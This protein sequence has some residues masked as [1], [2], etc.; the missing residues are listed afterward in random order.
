MNFRQRL[1]ICI[2]F[3]AR[4]AY[5]G[6]PNPVRY[7]GIEHGLSN[8]AV[9]CI[10]QD[11]NGF[12]W[13]GTYDGLNRY[14]GYVF[15][16][17]RNIIGDSA[18]L[19]DNHIYTIA[20]GADHKIWIGGAKG[21]SIFN[22]ALSGFSSP[23]FMSWDRPVVKDIKEG[24]GIIKTIHQ[25]ALVLA[26]T[27]NGLL[28]FE[29]NNLVGKQIP[30][31]PFKGQEG[32]YT[33]TS[34]EYDSLKQF[35]W[36]FVQQ[37]GLCRFDIKTRTLAVV[38]NSIKEA[39]CMKFDNGG[40]LW[41]GNN[42]GLYK[43]D[44]HR[45]SYSRN[46]M[47][48]KNSVAG[49]CID[50]QNTVWIA[51]DGGGVWFLS[52]AALTPVPYLS[53]EGTPLVNSN[54]VYAIY[55]DTE[56][57]KWIGT[58]RGGINI[59][60]PRTSSFRNITYTV[61]GQNNIINNFILS[62][63][64][65]EK[66][67][68]WIGTDGAGLRYWDR[69][70]NKSV[71]YSN[72]PSQKNS[73]SSNFITSILRDSRNTIWVSTWFG[74]INRLTNHAGVF[75]HYTCFNPKTNAEENNVWLLY[76]DRQQ[77]IWASTT[78][79]GTLYLFN[80]KSNK[81]EIFDESIINIQCLAEDSEGNFWGGNYT[82]L[83]AIDRVQ[84]KHHQYNIGYPVRCI[85]EDK[86]K[87]FWIG[88]EGG[89]LLLFDRN[90][91]SYQRYTTTEG[92]PSNTILRL[93]EDS[94][95]NLW[96]STYNGL[97]KFNPSTKTS[98]NF[99][100]SDG[101]QSNQFSFNAALALKTGEFL[102]GGIKG[103]NIF[104][105][106][107]VY[108][109]TETPRIFLT[110]LK[111]NNTP[112]EE[113]NSYITKREFEKIS[114]V[115]V[116][117]DRAIVS[118]D[119]IALEYTGADKIKYAYLLEGWDKNW[120][121]VNGIRGANY[122]RLQEGDYTFKIKVTNAD[123]I[124]GRETQL[125]KIT[126]LPP[127]YRTWWIYLLYALSVATA[128][129]LYIQYNKRQERLRYEIKLA[130]LEKEK[131]KELTEKKISFFTHISHEFRT[132]LT[133]IINPLKEL[134]KGK[135]GQDESRKDISMIYRNARR[136]LSLVDQLLLFRKVESIDQQM[137]I[138]KFDI[139]EVCHEVF[140]SFSQHAVAKKVNFIYNRSDHE[141]FIYADK[142]KIEIILF[143]LVSNA[144][145]YTNAGGRITLVIAEDEKNVEI[146]VKDTGSGIPPGI[147]NK[148]FDSFYQADNKDK[149]SQTGFG[150]G[151]YVSQK[152][153]LAH[154]GKL[155][156][157]SE[158]GKGT[159][160]HLVL[161]KGKQHFPPQYISED[162]K[163]RQTIL[164]EL[165]EEPAAENYLGDEEKRRGNKSEVI[166][167]LTSELPTMV[168]VDDN[169]EIRSYIRHIFS[170]SFNLYEADDGKEGYELVTKE[171]PDIVI[172]DVMMKNIGGIE[173]CKR[174]K[175]TPSIAHTPVILLT[176]SS[177]DEAKLEGIEGGA[178]DYI[179]KPFDK[180][181]IVARVQNI[182]KG[183]NRLQRYFFNAVTLKPNSTIAGEHKEFIERCIAIVEKH[184]DN[185]D[186]SIQTFC[187]EIGMSHPSLYKKVKA[188]SGL[189]V[190]VFVRYLRLRKAAE[191][192]INTDKT[193]VE[194][195]YITGFNDIRYFREQFYNLFE[196][197]PSDYVKRYRKVFGNKPVDI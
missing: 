72:V 123:G 33:V 22:P 9:T 43:Y 51:S 27:H 83:V 161:Q 197:N 3:Y 69:E 34:I 148:L 188:V 158:P 140:L 42:N 67:N 196:M 163:E 56:G 181:I 126:V 58:L 99:S 173:L 189:T 172:S 40:D 107:S 21:I 138:E 168:I 30:L 129:Y 39:N 178:E 79:N 146:E 4:I 142:E 195:T 89:G 176:A 155:S 118:L 192:L 20:E 90:N 117:Y 76:E 26:G 136:L 31:Y 127:W 133:L 6:D 92:L 128:I 54:A 145:K 132:P 77:R 15:K 98:R 171:T 62:F 25:D 150:I 81:F 125:L 184:L 48:S 182:L 5:A 159:V 157:N 55:E 96:L 65:D 46:L 16:I 116:P 84:K 110:G 194:V 144:F 87:K 179:T 139:A 57:R 154:Q 115:T 190:N 61:P 32:D 50:K 14:D 59:I 12:M 63:C 71:Q 64:E 95:G 174:I 70:K 13:F 80:D 97:C 160:F 37:A 193:I 109:K 19:N 10:Y 175:G 102:F 113:D 2:L 169:A 11:H 112:V 8:N 137:R 156:Y 68:V 94:K 165:V 82:S 24:V 120:N 7:L 111:I 78:N 121:Y 134:I 162:Y 38:D 141:I 185:P 149:A 18:S 151:L 191:L 28:V 186:F 100:Q 74:G 104:Y 47:P 152:L 170:G 41:L 143:N 35:A 86:N 114:E 75:N 85:H 44:T 183:R 119:F 135:T 187:R 180:E 1:I 122:S 124:W 23:R 101:L 91:G 105:P 147:G 103:F 130:H 52:P 177:S 17:F 108:D 29:K 36:V 88:T 166:D 66:N 167:K 153:A 73:I 131:E 45:H 53:G 106:D 60:Q 164:H 93:L 49:L